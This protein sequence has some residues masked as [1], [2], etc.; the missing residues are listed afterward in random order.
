[1]SADWQTYSLDKIAE[2]IGGGT[3]KTSK[4]EYWEG[5][6]PW[7]SV[8]DFNNDRRYVNTAE[9]NMHIQHNCLIPIKYFSSVN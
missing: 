8:V 5:D 9:K 4:P 2:I 3:P 6:I 7:L 1:M